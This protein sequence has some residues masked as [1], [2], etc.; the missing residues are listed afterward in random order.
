MLTGQVP[1]DAESVITIIQHHY[2][3]P[4]PDIL[5]VREGVPGELLAVVY[6]ALGKDASQRYGS[7]RE[8]V[9]ALEAVPCSPEDRAQSEELLR[10]LAS[11]E[12]IPKVR[13]GSLPPLADARTIGAAMLA[14]GL[15]T[16]NTAPT[17]T[18]PSPGKPAAAKPRSRKPLLAAVALAIVVLGAGGGYL[19]LKGGRAAAPAS[20]STVASSARGAV[21]GQPAPAQPPAGQTARADSGGAPAPTPVATP[22]VS[23]KP[24]RRRAEPRAKPVVTQ[25]AEPVPASTGTGYLRLLTQPSN[26]LIF[27]DGRKIGEGTVF[28][29]EVPAGRRRL[30]ITAPGY[31]T[32]DTT[33]TVEPGVTVKVGTRS[34][35]PE[36]GP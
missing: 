27:L 15:P 14:G 34:L 20:D 13:T 10:E 36:G 17:I 5:S 9:K 11:G 32:Y 7:T 21:A 23:T 22:P 25:Q 33:I 28:D 19:A 31:V 2:F 35:R 30:R 1:F 26:A 29:L 24:T 3:T 6:R 12:A 16:I 4:V 18:A 8:M